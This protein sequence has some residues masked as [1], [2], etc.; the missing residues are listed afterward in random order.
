MDRFDNSIDI[1]WGEDD[2]KYVHVLDIAYWEA[3]FFVP[4]AFGGL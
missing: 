2:Q 3:L 1:G 4:G